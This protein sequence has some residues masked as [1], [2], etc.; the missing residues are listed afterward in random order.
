MVGRCQ[1]DFRL[2]W[3]YRLE[4]MLSWTGINANFDFLSRL[5]ARLLLTVPE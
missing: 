4:A 1:R 3:P 2:L 5:M